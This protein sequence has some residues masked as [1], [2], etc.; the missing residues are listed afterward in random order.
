MHLTVQSKKITVYNR[1]EFTKSSI[2]SFTLMVLVVSYVHLVV[3]AIT[4]NNTVS[5][6]KAIII[7]ST[8]MSGTG[9][10]YVPAGSNLTIL[11]ITANTAYE[12]DSWT[13]GLAKITVRYEMN[14]TNSI[15]NI[16]HGDK[17]VRISPLLH[18]FWYCINVLYILFCN[19]ARDP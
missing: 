7:N 6:P 13:C 4:T 16:Q 1:T 15:L 2:A 12:Q 3:A 17:D 5:Y 18:L 10:M 14:A 8:T 19:F 11:G 9:P